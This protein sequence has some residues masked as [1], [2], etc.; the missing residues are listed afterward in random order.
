LKGVN[1]DRRHL[2]EDAIACE[3]LT[4]DVQRLATCANTISKEFAPSVSHF[5]EAPMARPIKKAFEK[6]LSENAMLET[7]AV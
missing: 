3:R 1:R 7:I 6:W 5:E 4:L 2:I